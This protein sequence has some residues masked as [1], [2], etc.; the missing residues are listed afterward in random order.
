MKREET[1]ILN[2]CSTNESQHFT[3]CA[4]LAAIGVKVTQLKLFEPIR[5]RVQIRQKT[6]K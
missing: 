5:T 6:I 3:S 2:E 4:S 1:T